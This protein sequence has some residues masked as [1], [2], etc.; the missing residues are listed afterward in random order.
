MGRHQQCDEWLMVSS[1]LCILP[2]P[3]PTLSKSLGVGAGGANEIGADDIGVIV[4]NAAS[5][6]NLDGVGLAFTGGAVLGGDVHA[7]LESK[8]VEIKWRKLVGER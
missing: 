6:T 4:E 1:I 3:T 7:A 2:Y 8:T 5:A